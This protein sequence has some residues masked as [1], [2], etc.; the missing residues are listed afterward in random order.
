MAPVTN[1]R[2]P[3]VSAAPAAGFA[4]LLLYFA[5]VPFIVLSKEGWVSMFGLFG[6]AGVWGILGWFRWAIPFVANLWPYF[7]DFI[8]RSTFWVLGVPMLT[9]STVRARGSPPFCKTKKHFQEKISLPPSF[10]SHTRVSHSLSSRRPSTTSGGSRV[11]P[12][13]CNTVCRL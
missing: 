2:H 10:F 13:V 1:L 12:C 7:S 3:G 9:L 4:P 11:I 8:T 6:G 5:W